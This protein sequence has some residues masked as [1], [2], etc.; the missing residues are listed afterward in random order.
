M[1]AV[2]VW[3]RCH[4]LSVVMGA[5]ARMFCGFPA[6]ISHESRMFRQLPCEMQQCLITQV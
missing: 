3:E 2:P 6:A 1:A 4:P 5:N